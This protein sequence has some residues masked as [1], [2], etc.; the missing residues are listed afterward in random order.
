ML[1]KKICIVCNVKY[2]PMNGRQQFC[3]PGCRRV[4]KIKASQLRWVNEKP[5]NK[6]KSGFRMFELAHIS[7]AD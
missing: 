2:A 6:K 5:K 1:D 7:K 4:H 3:S